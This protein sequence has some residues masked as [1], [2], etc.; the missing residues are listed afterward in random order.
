MPFRREVLTGG[1]VSLFWGAHACRH[2]AAQERRQNPV[3]GCAI[4]PE[5][6]GRF[7]GSASES[8]LYVT[9]REPMIPRS[10]DRD[11]DFA[12]AQTL[13]RLSTAFDV[14]PGFAYFDDFD[15][16]NAYAT[17]AVRSN[18]PDGTVLFGERLLRHLMRALEHPDAAVAAVCAHEFAHILQF[19]RQLDRP[20]MR[21]GSSVRRVELQADFFAGYFAG[22]RRRERPDFPAAVFAATKHA[23]GDDRIHDPQHHGT[24]DERGQAVV[25]GFDAG[26]R[27]G[28][29]LP[30]A[31][32]AAVAY[33]R[34]L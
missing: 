28:H 24:P 15:A 21:P 9:G 19:K 6:A 4:P 20:L 27:Q 13:A 34:A 14:R 7:F 2:C 30:Q 10:G 8:R 5:R 1:L 12:L 16:M 17:S 33:A 22:L 31:I 23:M 29:G 18:G 32:E 25:R 3:L 11:F 26:F